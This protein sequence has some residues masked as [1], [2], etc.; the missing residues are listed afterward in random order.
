MKHQQILIW[1]PAASELNLKL[2]KG[3]KKM[4]KQP[5]PKVQKLFD[6][7]RKQDDIVLILSH[8]EESLLTILKSAR[9]LPENRQILIYK[10]IQYI[11]R[12]LKK[13]QER[14]DIE[15]KVQEKLHTRNM[16]FLKENED[17]LFIVKKKP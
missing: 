2:L 6:E 16:E 3:V 17:N 12:R 13:V 1:W 10:E 15:L 11:K 7:E 8:R 9:A 5:N 4:E 14:L